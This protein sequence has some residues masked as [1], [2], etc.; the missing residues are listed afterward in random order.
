MSDSKKTGFWR[1]LLD[2]Y[3]QL[4]KDMGVDQGGCRSCVP[5][6]QFDENGKRIETRLP[7]MKPEKAEHTDQ[8]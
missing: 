2:S 1:K 8:S 5:K 4:C 7:T 3:N 6:Y